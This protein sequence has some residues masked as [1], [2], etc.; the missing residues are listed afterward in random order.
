ME[1]LTMKEAMV[2]LN[3]QLFNAEEKE[4]G[5]FVR[6]TT[7]GVEQKFI[8]SPEDVK[9]KENEITFIEGMMCCNICF[10]E[11]GTYKWDETERGLVYVDPKEV[12]K[13][14]IIFNMIY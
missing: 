12:F 3:E 8:T 2:K 9:F 6:V 11:D 13:V 10:N 7:S 1:L 5:V 4:F 14:S